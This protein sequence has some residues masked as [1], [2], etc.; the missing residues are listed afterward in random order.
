[1]TREIPEWIGATPDS[2]IPRRVRLR[3]FER[4]G[5]ICYLS[6]RKIQPG[7]KWEVDHVIP[8]VLGGENREN[9]LA[10]ALTTEHR[11]K[12]AADVAQKSKERRVRAKHIGLHRP[13]AVM[14]GSRASGWKKKLS[15][16]VV[17]RD[18]EGK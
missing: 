11:K 13:K 4:H 15:G 2:A 10:P 1:M 9:N 17:R 7:D 5:G 8:I 18:T 16:E 14:M 12:T 6:N 3:V